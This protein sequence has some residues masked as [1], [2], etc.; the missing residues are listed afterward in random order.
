METV[1]QKAPK[2]KKRKPVSSIGTQK[3]GSLHRSLKFRYSG[4][5]GETEAQVGDYICDG[6]RASGELIE[7]QTS[8]FGPLKQK[9]QTLTKKNKVRIVYPIIASKNIELYDTESRLIRRRKS[10]VKGSSWDLF[11]A[12][13]YAPELPLLKNLTIELAVVDITEKRIDDG[14]GSWRRK[15]VR[16]MDK[17][18]AAWNESIVLSNLKHYK[19]FVPFRK[20][21][22]FTAR[23][24]SEKA[25]ISPSLAQKAIYSLSKMGLVERKGKQGNAFV[26][27]R[28]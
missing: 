2:P 3:E 21:E 20:N 18:I 17:Y 14:K 24:L 19:Q 25:G 12:L 13:I 5:D 8:S 11:S 16:I 10:P 9:I 26:Y 6:R 28:P 23:N 22:H 15:G 7:V 27:V 4:K 1:L